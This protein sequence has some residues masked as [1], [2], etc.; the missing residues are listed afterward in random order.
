[1]FLVHVCLGLW[2]YF[3][4]MVPSLVE[5]EKEEKLISEAG[6]LMRGREGSRG[7]KKGGTGAQI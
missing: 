6:K 7:G 3:W 4:V 5:V 2:Y 1:M